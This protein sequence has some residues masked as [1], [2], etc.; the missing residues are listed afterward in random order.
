MDRA[1][2]K[3]WADPDSPAVCLLALGVDRYRA[4]AINWTPQTW[5]Q[6]IKDDTGVDLP[7]RSLDRLSAACVL[8]VHPHEFY[9][10]PAT[11]TDI[12]IGL[13]AEWF[14]T[15]TWHPP[16]AHECAWGLIEAHL[17]HPPENGE[18]F[19]PEIVRYVHMLTRNDGFP[20]LPRVFGTFGIGEDDDLPQAHDYTD[21]PDMAAVV[22]GGIDGREKDLSEWV[23][24]K[25]HDLSARLL[26]LPLTNTKNVAGVAKVLSQAAA[27]T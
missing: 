25:L 18:T 17:I 4:Q 13:A 27:S 21:D 24:T 19:S 23:A 10:S 6:E 14:D 9:R 8:L 26:D 15:H 1:A 12:V 3:V 22:A 5:V 11:F 7:A 16:T 2:A 20:Q